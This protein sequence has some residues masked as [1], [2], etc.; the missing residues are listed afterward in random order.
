MAKCLHFLTSVCPIFSRDFSQYWRKAAAQNLS[1]FDSPQLRLLYAPQVKKARGSYHIF[2]RGNGLTFLGWV[3][4]IEQETEKEVSYFGKTAI[5]P[6]GG[7]DLEGY[8]PFRNAGIF[9]EFVSA[10]I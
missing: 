1:G 6:D 10:I 3:A 4:I 5:V 8:A 2:C 7:L 9:R